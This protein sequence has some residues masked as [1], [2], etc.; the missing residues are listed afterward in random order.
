MRS[1]SA[2]LPRLLSERCSAHIVC[3]GRHAA[4]DAGAGVS[5]MVKHDIC[6]Q[7]KIG[8]KLSQTS[9]NFAPLCLYNISYRLLC[10]Q[11]YEAEANMGRDTSGRDQ[12]CHQLVILYHKALL[13]V[14]SISPL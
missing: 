9:T 12:L 11:V 10:L 1:L 4:D 14:A 8:V 5:G 13:A 6:S 7:G 3:I 2:S